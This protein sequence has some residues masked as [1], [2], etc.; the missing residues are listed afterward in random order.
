MFSSTRKKRPKQERKKGGQG[1]RVDEKS[2]EEGERELGK[3][4]RG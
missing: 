4:G 2:E 3:S 1:S